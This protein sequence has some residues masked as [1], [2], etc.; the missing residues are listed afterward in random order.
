M[1]ATDAAMELCGCWPAREAVM[2]FGGCWPTIDTIMEAFASG[3]QWN[4]SWCLVVAAP[5]LTRPWKHL[6]L[7]SNGDSHGAW[8]LLAHNGWLWKYLL[9][10]GNGD[11]H[12]GGW[13]LTSTGCS[14]VIIFAGLQWGDP[15]WWVVAGPQWSSHAGW[16]LLCSTG[17]SHGIIAVNKQWRQP[18]MVAGQRW[19]PQW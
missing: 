18:C 2:V 14:H 13:T 6:L 3:Q 8:R 5:Q 11:S 4:Q 15:W 16:W 9:L 19:R 17:C 10:A 12:G 1:P 7:A